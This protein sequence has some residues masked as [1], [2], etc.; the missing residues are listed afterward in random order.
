MDARQAYEE[1]PNSMVSGC[2]QKLASRHWALDTNSSAITVYRSTDVR[3]HAGGLDF[4]ASFSGPN[5]FV[6]E[7]L[8][9][10]AN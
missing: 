6:K 3:V 8:S 9:A 2:I 7:I 10:Y 1:V 4:A 5:S